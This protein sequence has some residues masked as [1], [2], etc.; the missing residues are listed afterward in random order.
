M[1]KYGIAGILIVSCYIGLRYLWT[2]RRTEL[3]G[4]MTA[5]L[6]VGILLWSHPT[7]QP[8]RLPPIPKTEQPT[9]T[10]P[11]RV[12]VDADV[13][14]V[15][16]EGSSTLMLAVEA[17]SPD[18]VLS[19][20]RRGADVNKQNIYGVMPLDVAPN[21]KM[22]KLLLEHGADPNRMRERTAGGGTQSD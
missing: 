2:K 12:V 14:A 8:L 10:P 5:M 17:N 20:I 9:I 21:I 6:M 3:I 18:I 15:D 11:P 22:L 13:L 7:Q 16:S 4:G 1:D 19:L